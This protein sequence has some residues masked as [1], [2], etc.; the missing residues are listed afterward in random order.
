MSE[1]KFKPDKIYLNPGELKIMV[2][3]KELL[4]AKDVKLHISPDQEPTDYIAQEQPASNIW[5]GE[6]A[7]EVV[8]DTIREMMS[9]KYDVI[10]LQ[11]VGKLPRKMK[12]TLHS[13]RMTKW[14]RK[15][16]SYIKR[17][18]IRIH[19]AEMVVGH[20]HIEIIK[21]TN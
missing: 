9:G 13:K 20:D 2:G 5:E 14:K 1:I 4:H 12:K 6:V 19:D 18:Q 8:G 15:V 7:F 11:E 21:V 3:G 16:A 17:R 10:I